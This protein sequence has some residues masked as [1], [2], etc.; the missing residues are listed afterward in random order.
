MS[1]VIKN[2]QEFQSINEEGGFW[3]SFGSSLMGGVKNVAVGQ[4]TDFLLSKLGV[5]ADTF[6]GT[7]V[8]NMVQSLD[9][10]EYPQFISGNIKVSD[11]APKMADATIATLTDLGVDGIATRVLKLEPDQKDG[12][13]YKT[14]KEMISNSASKN[15]FRETLVGFWTWVLGGSTSPSAER[16]ESP[17]GVIKAQTDQGS[18][19]NATASQPSSNQSQGQTSSQK[20]SWE[21]ILQTISGGSSA[22]GRGTTA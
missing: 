8:R 20:T 13:V 11:I 5:K 19:G 9:L 1:S 18:A 7:V 15:D 4:V 14:I 16:K 22:Q 21:N 10:S 17:F 3:S 12:L 2:F 6:G